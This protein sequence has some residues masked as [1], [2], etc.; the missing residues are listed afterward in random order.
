MRLIRTSIRTEHVPARWGNCP[1][2]GNE[3]SCYIKSRGYICWHCA[4]E[5]PR[6]WQCG[7]CKTRYTSTAAESDC[8][9]CTPPQTEVDLDWRGPKGG[10]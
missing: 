7:T 5:K 4:H 9:K 3:W 10:G 2:C 1:D 8:P 6:E